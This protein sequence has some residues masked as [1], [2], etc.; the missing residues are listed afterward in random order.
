MRLGHSF[1]KHH[2]EDSVS[3]QLEVVYDICTHKRLKYNMSTLQGASQN[4][5]Y[6]PCF[7]NN[8]FTET[9]I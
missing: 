3:S 7:H 5:K 9:I 4:T 1:F 8:A 6:M 2:K